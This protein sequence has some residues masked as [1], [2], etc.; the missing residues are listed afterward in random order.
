MQEITLLL[1][2]VG[3]RLP[4]LDLLGQIFS[5]PFHSHLV[6]PVRSNGFLE[7]VDFIILKGIVTILE[8]QLIDHVSEVFLFSLD[9][10]VV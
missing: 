6:V 2:V 1:E 4:F 7:H 3:S 10:D 8:V 5:F 9:V